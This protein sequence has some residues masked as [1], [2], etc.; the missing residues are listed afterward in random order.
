MRILLVEDDNLIGFCEK[1]NYSKDKIYG[2]IWKL[3][4][5]SL[6]REWVSG[7]SMKDGL[8]LSPHIE[9]NNPNSIKDNYS[10]FDKIKDNISKEDIEILDNLKNKYIKIMKKIELERQIREL[11]EKLEEME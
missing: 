3:P 1:K 4:N 7:G 8:E 2:Y 11:Q 6:G 10:L 5:N 9:K